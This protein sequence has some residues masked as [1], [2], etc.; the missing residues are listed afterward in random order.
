[1]KIFISV[2]LL[3]VIFAFAQSQVDTPVMEVSNECYTLKS[4]PFASYQKFY[5]KPDGVPYGLKKGQ[6]V[7]L[8]FDES[9]KILNPDGTVNYVESLKK[10]KEANGISE[11]VCPPGSSD[12]SSVND[13]VNGQLPGTSHPNNDNAN[14]PS[15]AICNIKSEVDSVV[16]AMSWQPAF[17]EGK[18]DKP[19]C[20][21]SQF[22]SEDS[23]QA[24]NFTLHG[25]WPN[26]KECGQN[27]GFCGEVKTSSK[28]FCDYPAV[29]IKNYRVESNLNLVMPSKK[30]GSCLDRH[31]WHKHGTCQSLNSSVY[32]DRA[33][34]L[35]KN[36]NQSKTVKLVRNHIRNNTSS[37]LRLKKSELLNSLE[38][39]FGKGSSKNFVIVCKNNMLTEI[40]VNLKASALDAKTVDSK[41]TIVNLLNKT[42]KGY[43]RGCGEE[44]VIDKIGPG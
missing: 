24:K 4:K 11:E 28:N 9:L 19:E 38:A 41:I 7:K 10:F 26:K 6:E 32:F 20:K 21:L 12:L 39:S 15:G 29:E 25:L 1:M 35:L 8:K 14:S 3:S 37:G 44:I 31:E 16:L 23:Y 30:S 34:K 33:M 17:C 22:L 40:Q 36:F 42:A 18:G 5:F 43:I 27:Y 13:N 2:I